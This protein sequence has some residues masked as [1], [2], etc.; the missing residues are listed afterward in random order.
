MSKAFS[1]KAIPLVTRVYAAMYIPICLLTLQAL[2][3]EMGI[4]NKN[5]I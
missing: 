1:Y 2:P 4:M 5:P 3:V